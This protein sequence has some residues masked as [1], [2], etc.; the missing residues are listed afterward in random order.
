[1]IITNDFIFIH[2]PKARGSFVKSILSHLYAIFFNNEYQ[3]KNILLKCFSSKPIFIKD[4]ENLLLGEFLPVYK[5][6]ND[7]VDIKKEYLNKP[8]FTV[9][10]N[11]V[12]FYNSFFRSKVWINV[13]T[14][15]NATI[16]IKYPL[17]PK[18]TFEEFIIFIHWFYVENLWKVLNIENKKEFGLYTIM[19][20]L[21]CSRNPIKMLEKMH[22]MDIS[23]DSFA[24][25]LK[26]DEM[27]FLDFKDLRKSLK[28]YFGQYH[29]LNKL[30][31]IEE[32][33]RLYVSESKKVNIS[34]KILK[35]IQEI[36]YLRIG[37]YNSI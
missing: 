1:M 18:L 7:I 6:H 22:T 12:D 4:K 9:L 37:F 17:F 5:M 36:D 13:R 15:N 10:R 2:F 29:N 28:T 24:S 25:D 11:G 19:L 8:R 33:P 26:E 23:N 30:S 20:V 35:K 34:N 27:T 3:E 14:S 31:F 21:Q 32:K 16:K